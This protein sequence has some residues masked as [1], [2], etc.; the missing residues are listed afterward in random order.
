MFSSRTQVRTESLLEG[1]VVEHSNALMRSSPSHRNIQPSS[2]PPQDQ[3]HWAIAT[4]S[5][6]FPD[7]CNPN[8]TANRQGHVL[9]SLSRSRP[10]KDCA[11]NPHPPSIYPRQLR[12]K[13]PGQLP[14]Q[15]PSIL[16]LDLPASISSTPLIFP[17]CRY[18]IDQNRNLDNIHKKQT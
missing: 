13:R 10:G 16:F 5:A 2:L 12:P 17:L 14:L 15:A 7:W 18:C 3:Q 11:Y 1:K 4:L 9:P 8:S 6:I